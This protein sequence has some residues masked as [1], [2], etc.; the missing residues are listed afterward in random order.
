[1]PNLLDRASIVLTPTAYDDGKVLC[2]KPID[3]SGDFDFSRNSAA[4]RVNAQGLV[5]DVQILSSNL[6]TNGD[7]SNGSTGW[8]INA[9]TVANGKASLDGSSPSFIS[10]NA[11]L[12]SGKTYKVQYTVSDYVSGNVRFRANGVNGSTNVSNGVVSDLITVNSTFLS[13]QGFNG[14]EGSI[15][16]IS[17]IEIT[18]DTNLPRINYEGFSYDGSGDIIPDSGCGSWLFEPQSTNIVTYSEKFSD[19][20]W[21]KLGNRSQV[22]DNNVISPDGT[23]NAS[24]VECIVATSNAA[25]RFVGLT[26]GVEYTFS[27][28]A[29]K[30][31]DDALKL[32]ISDISTDF[33][34]TDE[35]MRYEITETAVANFADFALNNASVG[36]FFYVWGAQIE[37]LSHATSYIPTNGTSVTRNK[38]VCT[39]G[40]SIATISSTS[41]VLYA[42]I[43]SLTQDDTFRIISL[44]DGQDENRVSIAYNNVINELSFSCRVNDVNQFVFTKTLADT[45]SFH[46]FALSYKLNE[47]KV[48]IDGVQESVQLSGS[49]YPANTL[50]ELTF[51]RGLSS[52]PFLGK[53]KCLA[54]WKEALTDTELQEL[55]TI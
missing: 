25:L 32:D 28:Y 26:I 12:V 51:D 13:I 50:N 44:C 23:Q 5:E 45:T 19:S 15:S 29:K 4:T 7:F 2:A 33:T 14:F 9:W 20:S 48:Y 10:Q 41:G 22:T 34:L 47:F 46:K 42:E 40:G 16:N 3:G 30:G 6:V 18:D 53:T 17:A 49:V 35:W 43:A 37:E 38:D 31:N 54:V 39:N 55:T 21:L 27:L 11:I 24:K 1:M 8:I 36:D 52:F